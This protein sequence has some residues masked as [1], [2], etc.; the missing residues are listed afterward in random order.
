MFG[1]MR[2]AATLQSVRHSPGAL[3]A[4]QVLWMA[5]RNGARTLGL[6]REIGSIQPGCRA[7]LILVE[8]RRAHLQPGPDPYST[9][10]YAARADDV[11]LTMVDGEVLVDEFAAT[12][13]DAGEVA[14]TARREAGALAARAGL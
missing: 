14:E 8:Q 3:T 2:L 9:V 13:V 5:T 12:R 6:E 11:R 4:R 7:D 1:E 10:V